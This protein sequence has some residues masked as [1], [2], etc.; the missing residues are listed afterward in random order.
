VPSVEQILAAT[1][2]LMNAVSVDADPNADPAPR[3][4]RRRD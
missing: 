4:R 2:P 1:G 3:R